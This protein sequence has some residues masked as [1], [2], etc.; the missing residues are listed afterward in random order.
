MSLP[1]AMIEL[2]V[3]ALDR[4]PALGSEVEDNAVSRML[5]CPMAFD[6]CRVVRNEHA[7]GLGTRTSLNAMLP[8][9]RGPLNQ[10]CS[11]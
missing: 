9:V 6:R 4:D 5:A 2:L 8:T 7:L 10:L 3:A 1:V 11:S